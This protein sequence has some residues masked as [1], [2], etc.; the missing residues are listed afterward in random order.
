MAL[1]SAGLA[2]DF[3]AI[4]AS[5]P[6]PQTPAFRAQC[7]AQALVS[8]ASG[9]EPGCHAVAA[10]G[11]SLQA[12]LLAIFERPEL[13]PSA[14]DAAFQGFAIDL[15][16]GMR[17]M[18]SAQPPA[19]PVGFGEYFGP[20]KTPAAADVAQAIDLWMRTGLALER[21]SVVPWR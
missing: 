14:L 20:G 11:A 21:G 12:A 2:A 19:R 1:D 18:H 7:W 9:V 16:W 5:T 4:L 8:Y 13:D 3:E 15:C 6:A 10:A 17:Q